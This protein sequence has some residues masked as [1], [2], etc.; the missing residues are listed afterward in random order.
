MRRLSAEAFLLEVVDLHDCDRIVTFLTAEWGRKRG[1]SRGARTKYSRFAGQL[2]LLA[3]VDI[4]WFEKEGRDLV[5]IESVELIRPC[6]GVL[7]TLEGILM[8]SYFAEHLGTF[9]QENEDCTDLM[10]LLE[11]SLGWLED[12]TDPELVAR[13]F[14]VWVLR[15]AGIFPVPRGCTCCGGDLLEKGAVLTRSSDELLCSDCGRGAG[16]GGA[17]SVSRAA[18]TFLRATARHTPADLGPEWSQA[19]VLDEVEKLAARVRVSFLQQ[20]LR[21][22]EVMQQTLQR[23]RE[24]AKV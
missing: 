10:R 1:V 14:E 15:L 2:Q 12:G 7:E 11:R 22:Y 21:S 17:T 18:L 20:E 23:Q 13:Y 6:R 24:M 5:R 19:L 4:G 3:K 16:G 9:A 8:V